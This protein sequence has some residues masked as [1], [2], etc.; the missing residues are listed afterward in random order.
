[1][2]TWIKILNFRKIFDRVFYFDIFVNH[3]SCSFTRMVGGRISSVILVRVAQGCIRDKS[4]ES[5]TKYLERHSYIRSKFHH[6]HRTLRSSSLRSS[7]CLLFAIF[8]CAIFVYAD[9]NDQTCERLLTRER[10]NKF[11]PT[12]ILWIVAPLAIDDVYEKGCKVQRASFVS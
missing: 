2:L 8:D 3:C 4:L 12:S 7:Q 1:M 9:F 6:F 10:R 5:S 11:P